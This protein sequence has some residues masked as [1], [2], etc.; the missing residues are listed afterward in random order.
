MIAYSRQIS[1]ALVLICSGYAISTYRP[2]VGLTDEAIPTGPE[3]PEGIACDVVRAYVAK[4]AL[5]F[6]NS[7]CKVSC[8]NGFD[9]N[10]AY[11]SLLQFQPIP[12]SSHSQPTPELFD[13]LKITK[14]SI[15]LQPTA[16]PAND[17][18]ATSDVRHLDLFV[19][20]GALESRF[21]DVISQA[22]NGNEYLFPVEV[23]HIADAKHYG[24]PSGISRGRHVAASAMLNGNNLE[25]HHTVNN[26]F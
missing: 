26:A 1:V 18:W 12:L 5:L 25:V 10:E 3:T 20:F 9:A 17:L 21:V 7:R 11:A 2:S 6:H 24:Q 8:E 4:D 13:Q 15:R 16:T 22:P 23:M 19:N 14:A